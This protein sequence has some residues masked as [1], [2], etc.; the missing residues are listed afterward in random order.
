MERAAG[1]VDPAGTKDGFVWVDVLMQQSQGR[2][3]LDGRSGRIKTLEGLV[4]ERN[5][6]VLRQHVP[7][8]LADPI[9]KAVRIVGRHR[10]HSEN[11]ATDHVEH[12]DRAGLG[13]KPTGRIGLKPAINGQLYAFTYSVGSDCELAYD[14]AR[15][16]HFGPARAGLARQILLERLLEHILADLHARNH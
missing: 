4:S 9:R 14:L 7:F 12:H 11:T 15:G 1:N 16:C 3:R 5:A 2:D 8:E 13:S 10:S 6:F